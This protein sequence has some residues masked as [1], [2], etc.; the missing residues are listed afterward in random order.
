MS[1]EMKKL[2]VIVSTPFW[3]VTFEPPLQ[4]WLEPRGEMSV[5]QKNCSTFSEMISEKS[6]AAE[7]D[8]ARKLAGPVEFQ[9]VE[10][11]P[12]DS[13]VS[14]F[15]DYASL[16]GLVPVAAEGSY[17]NLSRSLKLPETALQLQETG[18]VHL[19]IHGSDVV[20]DLL[21]NKIK[22][23]AFAKVRVGPAA[24]NILQLNQQVEKIEKIILQTKSSPTSSPVEAARLGFRLNKDELMLAFAALLNPDTLE[25]TDV[26]QNFGESKIIQFEKLREAGICELSLSL[27]NQ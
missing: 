24:Q 1:F 15:A 22:L 2:L 6:S 17:V 25:L 23:K 3:T 14:V 9:V 26:W 20:C 12:D 11:R 19:V 13:A 7:I 8:F 5:L 4:Q 27:K 21:K 16:T 10:P 18:G